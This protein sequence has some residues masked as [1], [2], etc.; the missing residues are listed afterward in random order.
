MRTRLCF[1]VSRA[2]PPLTAPPASPSTSSSPHQLRRLLLSER[3]KLNNSRT[4]TPPN[5]PR[6]RALWRSFCFNLFQSRARTPP[7]IF[8]APFR[9]ARLGAK[10]NAPSGF[11]DR[12]NFSP[13]GKT[14][15]D[16]YGVRTEPVGGTTGAADRRVVPMGTP[17][18]HQGVQGLCGWDGQWNGKSAWERPF[19]H[20]RIDLLSLA[21]GTRRLRP[22]R[23]SPALRPPARSPSGGRAGAGS[24]PRVSSTGR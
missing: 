4:S 20:T 8:F 22:E 21:T 17:C 24:E 15:Q 6:R 7:A 13:F 14:C 19:W 10:K 23:A 11:E 12:P 1:L 9:S 16:T 18:A 2:A 5:R 3:A